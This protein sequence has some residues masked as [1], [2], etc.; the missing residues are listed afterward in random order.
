MTGFGPHLTLDLKKCSKERLVDKDFIKGLLQN[1]PV[2]LGL[3]LISEPEV[4]TYLDKFASTPGVT[5]FVVLAESHFS[6]HTFPDSKYAFVDL[7]SCRDFDHE[8]AKDM[9]VDAMKAGSFE[10]NVIMRGKDFKKE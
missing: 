6:I 1:I 4:L 10:V 9:I 5:G 8:V 7:F 2:K 3:K